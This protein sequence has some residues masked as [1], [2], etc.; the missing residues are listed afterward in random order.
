MTIA[1]RLTENP[2]VHVGVLEAG[3]NRLGDPLVDTPAAF[4]QML[5]NPEYDYMIRT[6]R[7]SAQHALPNLLL[8][9][10]STG[11]QP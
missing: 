11:G 4:L 2:D 10:N 6:P 9:I 1:A 5:G 7:T 3:P 8:S